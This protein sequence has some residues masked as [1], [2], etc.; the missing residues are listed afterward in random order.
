MAASGKIDVMTGIRTC[1]LAALPLALLASAGGESPG[2]RHYR[3]YRNPPK[4]LL[5][6]LPVTS[7]SLAPATRQAIDRALAE[8]ADSVQAYRVFPLPSAIRPDSLGQ[9]PAG[10]LALLRERHRVEMVLQAKL[11]QV[12]GRQLVFAEIIDTRNGDIRA[13][14]REDCLCPEAELSARVAPELVRRLT[15]A[16]RLLAMR[17]QQGMA[18]IPAPVL[19]GSPE[20]DSSGGN[21]GS[22]AF[23]MDLYEYPNE[24][25]GEPEAEKTWSEA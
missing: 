7:R 23:C 19:P 9:L 18:L 13:K 4:A 2:G 11:E 24:P 16:P 8:A 6:I 22:G 15:S 10:A 1:F 25:A 21:R 17:C 12:S 14:Y 3:M 20:P 5:T